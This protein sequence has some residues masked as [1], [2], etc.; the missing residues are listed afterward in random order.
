VAS[1]SYAAQVDLGLGVNTTHYRAGTIR[2]TRDNGDVE[3]ASP[4][5][6]HYSTITMLAQDY[7]SD[8]EGG[9]MPICPKD[10]VGRELLVPE[11]LLRQNATILSPFAPVTVEGQQWEF[12]LVHCKISCV[13]V[14]RRGHYLQMRPV[15]KEAA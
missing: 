6:A 3:I 10:W 12:V 4:H 2:W 15:F 7:W 1:S 11:E 5:D 13:K 14:D 8:R 9:W